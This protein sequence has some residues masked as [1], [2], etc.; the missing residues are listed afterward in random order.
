MKKFICLKEPKKV[1]F[2]EIPSKSRLYT[3][4]NIFSV[5]SHKLFEKIE[6]Q[7][8]Y[9]HLIKSLQA[10]KFIFQKNHPKEENENYRAF[11]LTKIKK[12]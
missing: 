12:S 4:K 5:Q 11:N 3:S 1:K 2:H 10:K 7:V 9:S 8:L 6:H